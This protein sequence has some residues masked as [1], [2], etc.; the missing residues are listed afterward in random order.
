VCREEDHE[1]A[2]NPDTFA[3]YAANMRLA[4]AAL[5]CVAESDDFG[6]SESESIYRRKMKKHVIA[7]RDIPVGCLVGEGDI[8]FKRTSAEGTVAHDASQVVGRVLARP[9]CSGRAFCKEDF[10]STD[11]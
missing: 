10:V 6:M 2:L 4:A 5:G 3:V 7:R 9:V 8:D 11:A 1:S